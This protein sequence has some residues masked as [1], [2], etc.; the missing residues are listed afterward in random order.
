MIVSPA[1]T[2]KRYEEIT[3][4]P[5]SRDHIAD[6]LMNKGWKPKLYTPDGK[7]KVDETVLSSLEYPEAKLLAEHFL[8]QKRIGQLG[9]S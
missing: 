2:I 9:S 6:R 1:D 3:F 7:P 5:N 4:N 8:V